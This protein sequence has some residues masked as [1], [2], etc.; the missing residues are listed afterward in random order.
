MKKKNTQDKDKNIVKNDKK[1]NNI[2][3]TFNNCYDI[4]VSLK[5]SITKRLMP[6]KTKILANLASVALMSLYISACGN[7]PKT[8]EELK[9]LPKEE[10]KKIYETCTKKYLTEKNPENMD[11]QCQ[12]LLK[13]EKERFLRY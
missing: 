5:N 2:L 6:M 1:E 7:E 12:S 9:K 11:E 10:L 8:V 4:I 13:L 3:N